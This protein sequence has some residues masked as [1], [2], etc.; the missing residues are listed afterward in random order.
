VG[1]K[2]DFKEIRKKRPRS[3]YVYLSISFII[4]LLVVS[5]STALY[6]GYIRHNFIDAGTV[7]KII[8]PEEA[9]EISSGMKNAMIYGLIVGLGLI[10]VVAAHIIRPIRRLT[11]ATKKVASGD[12][13]VNI[14]IKRNDEI[15]DLT[16]NFNKMVQELNSIEYLRKDFISNVSHELKTPLASI[17]GF[18]KLLADDN[19]SKEERKE[20]I[21]IIIEETTRLSNISNNMIKLS[22]FENQEIITNKKEYRLDE[23]LRKAIIMLDEKINEKNIN[24][25]L[26]AKPTT[27]TEDADIVMEIW[28]NLLSN[29]IKYT[30]QNGKIDISLVQD[31]QFVKVSIKDNGI[32]IA[33]EKQDRIFE[34]FY[35]ADKSHSQEGSGLGLAI[36]KRIVD[37]IDGKIEFESEENKG[38][39][40]TVYIKKV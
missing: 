12:F 26:K 16:Y 25:S 15:G 27:I 5:L 3:L 13:N 34:K 36:V 11:E 38:T 9:S 30:K 29:A 6:F 31:E 1:E 19:L 4:I 7:E 10:I 40:F 24:V 23:Q 14:E 2:M 21:D 33:K 32:G 8:S 20:Y 37:L 18:T 22:K 28:L 35:Q 17:Q 39:V